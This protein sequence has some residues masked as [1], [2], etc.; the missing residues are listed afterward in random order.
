V[1]DLY[2]PALLTAFLITVIEMT[3][4]V[5]LVFALSADHTSIRSGAAGAIAGTA[6]V[7]AVAV[8]SVAVLL[9]VPHRDLLWGSAVVLLA[10]GVFLFR[11]T[12]RSYR[13]ARAPPSPT[14]APKASAH[15]LQFA[16]GF[17]VG[18]VE[19]V[20]TV[21]V[22]IALA[23]AGYP[24]SAVI[25]SLVGGVA[26]V[27]TAAAVHDRIRRIKVPW[28]KLGATSLLLSFA[29]FWG[30]EAA[31]VTWPGNDLFLVPLVLGMIALVRGVIQLGLP[32]ET[33]G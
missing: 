31:G 10:F 26:L 20:E 15:A 7:A 32:V 11:S 19:A 33:K 8:A 6:V 17:S 16:G 13:R 23:A 28:L 24:D 29:I 27:A 9:A 5:A 14:T 3:E 18:A 30:G 1:V 25:G 4:V 12:L 22:L 2:F 21:I